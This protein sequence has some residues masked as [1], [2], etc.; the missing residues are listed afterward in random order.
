ME[1]GG[2]GK[3]NKIKRMKFETEWNLKNITVKIL[4]SI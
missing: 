3:S 2:G 1:A 4:V